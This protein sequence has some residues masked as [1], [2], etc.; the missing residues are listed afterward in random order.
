M[1]EPTP[2]AQ[3][4]ISPDT[5]LR[6]DLRTFFAIIFAIIVVTAG[7]V[8]WGSSLQNKVDNLTDGQRRQG[9]AI[10]QIRAALGI[11]IGAAPSLNDRPAGP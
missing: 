8:L 10:D 11:R 2:G 4:A 7:A 5:Q 9:D 1:T 3:R 6:S